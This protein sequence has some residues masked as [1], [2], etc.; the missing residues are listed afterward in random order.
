MELEKSIYRV[1]ERVLANHNN[2]AFIKSMTHCCSFL[3]V[4]LL[5]LCIW[6]H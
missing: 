5:G 3:S 4:A 2:R 1:H 6:A